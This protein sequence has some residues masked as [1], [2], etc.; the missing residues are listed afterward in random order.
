VSQS[1]CR[2]GLGDDLSTVRW[3]MPP[4]KRGG[5]VLIGG[6]RTPL[7]LVCVNSVLV[8]NG[9]QVCPNAS[10]PQCHRALF[11]H[12]VRDNQLLGHSQGSIL[13]VNGEHLD[14]D[15]TGPTRC[16]VNHILKISYPDLKGALLTI[17]PPAGDQVM[18]MV[19]VSSGARCYW[20]AQSASADPVGP[21]SRAPNRS[22][23]AGGSGRR[24]PGLPSW[25][26][27]RQAG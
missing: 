3:W 23:L 4:V 18:P 21:R 15:L 9:H 19:D 26:V 16:H 14:V 6:S 24:Q 13:N 12:L 10:T 25:L 22:S 7:T 2:V 5:R 17:T 11:W 8:R 20:H 1:R 27:A